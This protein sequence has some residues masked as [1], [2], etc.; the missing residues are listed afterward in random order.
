MAIDFARYIQ[1][2]TREFREKLEEAR[3]HARGLR[4]R[5]RRNVKPRTKLTCLDAVGA[6]GNEKC[7]CAVCGSHHCV[8]KRRSCIVSNY[9][10]L[11]GSSI[12]TYKRYADGGRSAHR[13]SYRH[14][15]HRSLRSRL[16]SNRSPPLRA[17]TVRFSTTTHI[18]LTPAAAQLVATVETFETARVSTRVS[19]RSVS[20]KSV[21]L[22][23]FPPLSSTGVRGVNSQVQL[24]A[25]GVPARTHSLTSSLQV[26]DDR[27][28]FVR[29]GA[30][31]ETLD[32]PC[33]VK[34]DRPQF[35]VA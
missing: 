16:P 2:H 10:I 30:Q 22:T 19:R 32:T 35:P 23:F 29:G 15:D 13:R 12:L 18:C 25:E 21:V 31:V 17:Y 28:S 4:K 14:R 1:V 20:A 5:E 11:S 8:S 7:A 6:Y 27:P 24:H 33:A 34:L 9:A 3:S 26:A